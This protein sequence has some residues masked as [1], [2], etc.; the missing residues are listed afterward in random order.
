MLRLFYRIF[1]WVL[2]FSILV[3]VL[4]YFTAWRSPKTFPVS[5]E[6]HTDY[7]LLSWEDYSIVAVN[8]T[9]PF[10]Y[11]VDPLHT[12][13]VFFF[14]AEHGRAL[15]HPQYEQI[16]ETWRE[17][18]PTIALVE[19]RLGFFL[20][21][22]MDPVEKFGESGQVAALSRQSNIPLYSWEFSKE[23]EIT[24][25]LRTHDPEKIAIFIILR[26]Y[27]SR[28]RNNTGL[29]NA[30]EVAAHLIKERGSRKGIKGAIVSVEN[31]DEIWRRD[32]PLGPDWRDISFGTSMPGYIGELFEQANNVRDFHLL[33]VVEDLANSGERVYVTAGWSHVLRIEPVFAKQDN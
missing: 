15:D 1:R 22:I 20:P 33:N 5:K 3:V 21:Y 27:W 7:P 2:L 16:K 17:F 25:L 11:K 32:F 12:G 10:T 24:A 6:A 23:D 8:V 4:V 14:G 30:D 9:P 13:A 18:K 26:S 19:G 28:V 29:P 31:L